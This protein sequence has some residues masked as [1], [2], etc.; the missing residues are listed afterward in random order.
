M[1]DGQR[2]AVVVR[3]DEGPRFRVG[4]IRVTGNKQINSEALVDL[5]TTP[6]QQRAWRYVRGD[7]LSR[8]SSDTEADEDDERYWE[9][10]ELV[11]FRQDP[12]TKFEEGVRLALDGLGYAA[13]SFHVEMLCEPEKELMH[14]HVAILNESSPT[15]IG[16]IEVTGLKRDS[17]KML[18]EY[19]KIAPGDRVTADTLQRI[20]D[21]LADSCRYW[22]H[23]IEVL[24]ESGGDAARQSG[25]SAVLRLGLEEYAAVPPIG[26]PLS[27]TDEVL[28]KTAA[29]IKS[30][31]TNPDSPDLVCTLAGANL[32]GALHAT[33]VGLAADGTLAIEAR[34]ESVR[35]LTLDHSFVVGA[36]CAE[37]YD[38]KSDEKFCYSPDS[39]PLVQLLIAAEHDSEGKQAAQLSFGYAIGSSNDRDRSSKFP[40]RVRIAPVAVLRLAHLPESKVELRDG[41]L[42]LHQ[43][44][45]EL[46]IDEATGQIRS[47]QAATFPL[48]GVSTIHLET[49]SGAVVEMV[50]RARN[51]GRDYPN[52][53]DP[54]NFV[55][56]LVS[57]C[58]EQCERQPFI[59]RDSSRLGFCRAARQLLES[60]ELRAELAEMQ[61]SSTDNKDDRDLP[62]FQIADEPSDDDSDWFDRMLPH[63][64][65]SANV[66]F[67]Y[68]SMPWTIMREYCFWHLNDGE[69]DENFDE[70]SKHATREFD[71]LLRTN[72]A[73]PVGHLLL[74]HVF[75][76]VFY[77][78]Q[79]KSTAFTAERGLAV[80]TDVALAK[81]IELLTDGDHGLAIACRAGTEMLGKMSAE[82]QRQLLELVPEDFQGVIRQLIDRR[83]ENPD[84]PPAEAIKHVLMETWHSGLRD[85]VEAELRSLS[86]Q[87]AEKPEA[88]ESVVK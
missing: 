36:E 23:D 22:T 87:I 82:D 7:A 56:S 60:R 74:A 38:W 12:T 69:A 63:G 9:A 54:A 47:L 62:K 68:G 15:T 33:R 28:R 6:Q 81:D 43:D 61:S 3:I 24:V 41:V 52:R 39:P 65:A 48:V 2:R 31:V 21:E 67:P 18:L 14:A 42:K 13:A 77:P 16:R 27:A 8:T 40:G 71:R 29:W 19:L 20:S 86:V 45:L 34:F 85:A 57:F 50:D 83:N 17:E 76:T 53:R 1:R 79:S 80:V 25:A 5:L 73:G 11:D 51:R 49:R 70:F 84:E 55:V 44:E 66:L 26:E 75:R 10:G 59:R 88:D 4:E 46:E 78:S 64:P 30:L 35:G 37:I 32:G 58:L 72:D